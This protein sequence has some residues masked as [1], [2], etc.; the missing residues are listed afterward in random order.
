M[1]G[2]LDEAALVHE[3]LIGPAVAEIVGIRL[4]PMMLLSH[5]KEQILLG[6]KWMA[7]IID[8]VFIPCS[9]ALIFRA[10][11]VPPVDVAC[12]NHFQLCRL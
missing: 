2:T 12:R 1:L 4:Y 10:E 6:V 5:Q 7:K 11:K 9:F 8:F 3:N